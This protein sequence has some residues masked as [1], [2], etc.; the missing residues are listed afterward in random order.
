MTAPTEQSPCERLREAAQR[1]PGEQVLVSVEDLA[2]VVGGVQ[3][4]VEVHAWT[5]LPCD[6]CGD[7]ARLAWLLGELLCKRCRGGV[8]V[9]DRADAVQDEQRAEAGR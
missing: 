4:P 7:V 1:A 8:L 5:E 3:R 2:A 9:A 6:R